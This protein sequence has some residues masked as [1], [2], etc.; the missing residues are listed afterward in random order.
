MPSLKS[1][2]SCVF[3]GAP[4]TFPVSDTTCLEEAEESAI[5]HQSRSARLT[6]AEV[7]T[8]WNAFR[9]ILGSDSLKSDT[10]PSNGC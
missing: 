8:I 3:C 10:E 2:A 7:E 5:W 6:T 4:I 1:V 9:A